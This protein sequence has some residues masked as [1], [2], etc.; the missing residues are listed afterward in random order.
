VFVREEITVIMKKAVSLVEILVAAV[1]LSAVFAGL[2][3]S[4]VSV[5]QYINRANSRLA[6]ANLARGTL[7]SLSAYVKADIWNT[8]GKLNNGYTENAAV[9]V[10]G[11]SYNV[12]YSVADVGG[13]DFRQVVMN[14]TY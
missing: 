2:L 9:P 6:G 13:H 10:D 4:F 14:V 1:L 8:T 7:S 3:A 5:R 11:S 12:A